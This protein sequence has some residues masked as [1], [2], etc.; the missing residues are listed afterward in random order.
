MAKAQRPHSHS[1]GATTGEVF[2]DV[3]GETNEY[4]DEAFESE[5]LSPIRRT[6]GDEVRV[7]K[8]TENLD[9]DAA[10]PAFDNNS[11]PEME[12]EV[13]RF[14]SNRAHTAH[15]TGDDLLM[16]MLCC[17]SI[18]YSCSQEMLVSQL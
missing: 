15:A 8:G 2:N 10:L 11:D 1:G 7:G 18:D 14:K 6:S 4:G 16:Q 3:E 12:L 13:R 9:K 5:D 17:T